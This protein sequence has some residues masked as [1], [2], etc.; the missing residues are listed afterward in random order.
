MPT[1]HEPIVRWRTPMGA[2]NWCF[3]DFDQTS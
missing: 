1:A 2:R 3:T